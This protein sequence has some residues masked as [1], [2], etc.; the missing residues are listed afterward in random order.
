[1]KEMIMFKIYRYVGIILLVFLTT[2]SSFGQKDKM[3]NGLPAK[4]Y[5]ENVVGYY[6][7]FTTEYNFNYNYN[8]STSIDEVGYPSFGDQP[9]LYGMSLMG[10]T[11]QVIYDV[12]VG[13]NYRRKKNDEGMA[14]QNMNS[15]HLHFG[16]DVINN[17]KWSLFPY[18]G[19]RVNMLKYTYRESRSE[20]YD[21]AEY[22]SNGPE[23]FTLKYSKIYLDCGIGFSN[24]KTHRVEI[25]AGYN[26]PLSK[27]RW[28]DANRQNEIQ[29]ISSYLT[30]WYLR[31]SVGIGA[32]YRD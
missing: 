26:V 19:A 2:T 30:G 32:T 21:L 4:F 11:N 28:W 25:R 17:P 18:V 5:K 29:G 6:W 23:H 15:F 14:K 20:A 22:V 3:I 8:L 24:Q 27:N 31:L 12:G 7:S 9:M 10:I 13:I 16:Y 1:M